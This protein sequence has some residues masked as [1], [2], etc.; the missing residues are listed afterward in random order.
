M[1]ER[2]Q[3]AAEALG[4]RVLTDPYRTVREIHAY[5]GRACSSRSAA[6]RP[7]Q[8][9]WSRVC[10]ARPLAEDWALWTTHACVPPQTHIYA[11]QPTLRAIASEA[12]FFVRRAFLWLRLLRCSLALRNQ[13]PGLRPEHPLPVPYHI[14]PFRV[15]PRRGSLRRARRARSRTC[16]SPTPAVVHDLTQMRLSS[17]FVHSDNEA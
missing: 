10:T 9:S 14:P 16:A 7:L 4:M 6:T 17:L 3:D 5:V 12:T 2:R 13:A 15:L 8:R 11:W 1:M